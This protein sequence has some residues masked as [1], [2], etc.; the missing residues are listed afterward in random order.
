MSYGKPEGRSRHDQLWGVLLCGLLLGG[1]YL[2][3]Q[4]Q[5]GPVVGSEPMGAAAIAQGQELPISARA[6]I[7]SQTI[8]LEVAHT[9]EEQALGLMFR[10]SLPD[11]RGMLFPF[12]PPR[13]VSFWMKN[14]QLPLDMIF[15]RQGKVVAI[16]HNA[17]PCNSAEC[18]VYKSGQPVDQVIELRG[19]RAAELQLQ[20][21]DS[22]PITFLTS[23]KAL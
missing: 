5:L 19:G 12:Q 13:P 20:E 7:G 10:S 2:L 15:I 6:K 22:I 11:Q 3:L 23:P 1:G 14:C 18:P 8:E 21:G 17:P 4:P 9:P 16:A